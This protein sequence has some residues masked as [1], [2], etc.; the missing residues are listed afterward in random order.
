M[1]LRQ[2]FE[3]LKRLETC[4]LREKR[5]GKRREAFHRFQR[6]YF[7]LHSVLIRSAICGEAVRDAIR[8]SSGLPKILPQMGWHGPL[9]AADDLYDVWKDGD[10]GE[11]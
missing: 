11:G 9:V 4:W 2:E 6:E 8:E 3:N 7:K 5:P 10:R 1:S